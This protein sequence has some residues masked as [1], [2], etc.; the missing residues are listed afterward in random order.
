MSSKTNGTAAAVANGTPKYEARLCHVVKR[1]DF[2]GYGFNLH[3]EKGRPGQY[4][5][6]VDDGSPAEGA[7]LRQGDRIIE[8]NGHNITTETHKKVVELIKAVPNETRLLVIDPRADANDL[9][10]AL[11]KASTAATA[12]AAPS[13]NN[14]NNTTNGTSNGHQ[15]NGGK[16]HSKENGQKKDSIK[17]EA[18]EKSPK[19]NGITNN[20]I[21]NNN[22]NINSH[23]HQNGNGTVDST[24]KTTATTMDKI[25]DDTKKVLTVTDGAATGKMALNG[26]ATETAAAAAVT[27]PAPAA[28][29]GKKLNLP[30]TAAEMRAQLAARKKYDPKNDVCDLRKKY[31]IIQKM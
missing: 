24:T 18:D 4:I 7:G 8:V 30:M 1:A 16:L 13:N 10:M 11:A 14:N 31:E 17:V 5:G 3:A 29:E 2:D 6:K 22:N 9:K 19:S 12:A 26:T 23:H 25:I 28:T 15:E 20:S 27:T 21:I